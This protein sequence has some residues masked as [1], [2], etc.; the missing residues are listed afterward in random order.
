MLTYIQ[1]QRSLG[2]G[3]VRLKSCQKTLRKI[4]IE[5]TEL[6]RIALH[7]QSSERR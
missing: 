3:N 6:H 7:I 4:Y 1:G 2:Q 5:S